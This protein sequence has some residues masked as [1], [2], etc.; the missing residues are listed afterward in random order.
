MSYKTVPNPLNWHLASR[1]LLKAL[2]L[3]LFSWSLNFSEP[4]IIFLQL[5]KEVVVRRPFWTKGTIC[6]LLVF[7]TILVVG[8]LLGFHLSHAHR[9]PRCHDWGPN[10]EMKGPPVCVLWLLHYIALIWKCE[11]NLNWNLNWKCRS[12]TV[13]STEFKLFCFWSAE[14]RFESPAVTL[15]SLTK[16]FNHCFLLRMGCKAVGPMCSV[17]A[18]KEPSTLIEKGR[19]SSRCSWLDWQHIAPSAPCKPLHGAKD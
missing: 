19:G 14:C 18:L 12:R 11:L 3:S 5:E 15:V 16:T 9:T 17:N 2:F 4:E 1:P 8:A 13:E 10:C 7:L 6:S